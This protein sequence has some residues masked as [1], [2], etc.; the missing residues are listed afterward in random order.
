[1]T[2]EIS[3]MH[4]TPEQIADNLMSKKWEAPSF[5]AFIPEPVVEQEIDDSK[6]NPMDYD[7]SDTVQQNFIKIV[8][9]GSMDD[10]FILESVNNDE[11]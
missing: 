8:K 11:L 10:V 2:S 6:Y 1:M 9:G 4:G 7:Q 3:G 5:Q